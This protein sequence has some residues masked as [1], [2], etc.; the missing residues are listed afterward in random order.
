MV[1]TLNQPLPMTLPK[2]HDVV[3]RLSQELQGSSLCGIHSFASLGVTTGKEVMVAIRLVLADHLTDSSKLSSMAKWIES[4]QASEM[5]LGYFVELED[6]KKVEAMPNGSRDQI[7][8]ARQ[9]SGNAIQRALDLESQVEVLGSF[10]NFC[11]SANPAS[12]E[13]WPKVYERLGV[14]F[15]PRPSI[16]QNRG[17]CLGVIVAFASTTLAVSLLLLWTL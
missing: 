15:P 10:G 16:V 4:A 5:Q 13:Y 17:G 8:L 11:L 6:F 2:S 9:Y 3:N 7:A 12:T 14:P 1:F